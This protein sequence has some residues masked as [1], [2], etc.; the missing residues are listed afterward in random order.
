MNAKGYYP[1]VLIPDV[2]AKFCANNPF[3]VFK[4]VLEGLKPPPEQPLPTLV[5]NSGYVRVFQG[6][7]AG[8]VVLLVINWLRGFYLVYLLLAIFSELVL[9]VIAVARE[10]QKKRRLQLSYQQ[11]LTDYYQQLIDYESGYEDRASRLKSRQ[12][13]RYREQISLRQQRL[14]EL[15]INRVLL[16]AARES[17]ATEGAS[18][19]AFYS[20]LRRYFPDTRQSVVFLRPDSSFNYTADFIIY[21]RLTGLA[22]DCEIDEPYVLRT[23]EPH[24]CVDDVRDTQRNQFFM[25]NNWAVIRFSERQVVLQPDSC[26]KAIAL[27]IYQVTGDASYL[28][29]LR[30]YPDVELHKQWTIREAKQLAKYKYR[31]SYLPANVVS[32]LASKKASKSGARATNKRLRGRH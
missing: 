2:V 32:A 26:C 7:L 19:R 25:G 20:R 11:R 14:R 18:E 5:N 16:P 29:R 28:E 6:F 13:Q 9:A 27:L 17:T 3:P 8:L 12:A 1:I 21:H 10:Y 31:N 23:G 30:S 15:L 22:I 4:G 24:H